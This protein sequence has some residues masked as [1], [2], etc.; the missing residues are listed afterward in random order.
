MRI[1][2]YGLNFTPELTGVG[3]YTGE[4]A[5][6]LHQRQYDVRAISAPPY[7]PDWEVASGYSSLR[8]QIEHFSDI[9]VYRCPLW[10]PRHHDGFRRLIHLTSFALSSLPIVLCQGLTWRP[11]VIMVVAPTVFCSPAAWIAAA[12]GCAKA[13]LHFQDLEFDA[14]LQLGLLPSSARKLFQAFE[15]SLLHRFDY[16]SAISHE[17]LFQIQ[18]KGIEESRLFLLPNWTELDVVYPLPRSNLRDELEISDD[19]TVVLYSGNMGKK[20]GLDILLKVATYLQQEDNILFILCGNGSERRR[21]ESQANKLANLRFLNLQPK[22]RLNHLLNLADIH[23]LPQQDHVDGLVM[24]SKL[25]SILACGGAVIA[26]AHQGTELQD[27]VC[28]AGGIITP[29]SEVATLAHQIK[30]LALDKNRR[31]FMKRVARNYAV[32][33]FGKEEILSQFCQ[34]LDGMYKVC[35]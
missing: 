10:I 31:L 5:Q 19:T 32:E 7:Y 4:L 33:H 17:M 6:W 3:K 23:L 18:R 24:P 27:V 13:W 26:T 35:K 2:I 28:Q 11:E 34:Q 14:A 9:K 16:I 25:P 29:P 20:Q 1:L 12:L 8:Y 22:K 21:L 15:S 30:R